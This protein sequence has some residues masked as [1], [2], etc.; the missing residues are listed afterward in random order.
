MSELPALA[1][2]FKQQTYERVVK[3]FEKFARA[4]A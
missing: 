2:P 1:V 4:S 3:E